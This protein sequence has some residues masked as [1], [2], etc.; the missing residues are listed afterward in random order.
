[1]NIKLN[2]LKASVCQDSK[3]IFLHSWIVRPQMSFWKLNCL[4][5]RSLCSRG[6]T[7]MLSLPAELI[8]SHLPHASPDPGSGSSPPLRASGASSAQSLLSHTLPGGVSARSSLIHPAP[9]SPACS[10]SPLHS[11]L[12]PSQHED[13]PAL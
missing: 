3:S 12:A 6:P 9:T 2:F 13:T 1:M 4:N 10:V 5:F 7:A 8:H 11:P